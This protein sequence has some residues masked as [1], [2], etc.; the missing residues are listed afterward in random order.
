MDG[1]SGRFRSRVPAGYN[2]ANPQVVNS[3]SE[4]EGF[5]G[6][7]KQ[8]EPADDSPESF[9][10]PIATEAD[11]TY[12]NALKVRANAIC[13][14]LRSNKAYKKWSHNWDLL[15]SNLNSGKLFQRLGN[16]DADIAYVVNKGEEIKFRFRDIKRY[17]P[18]NIYQYVLY[19]EMAHMS[20]EELQHTEFFMKLLNIIS[21]AAFECGFIDLQRMP[22]SLYTTNG[23]PILNRSSMKSE[24]QEGTKWLTEANPDSA[25]YYKGIY[26]A[27]D[28]V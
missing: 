9:E 4:K 16:S 5:L 6:I 21:L 2:F 1:I 22:S 28:R 12:I 19:H 11:N 14:Y 20:T 8:T 3:K 24:I 7:K 23:A 15:K 27:V 13:E 17:A 18:I 25:A 26:D 10:N